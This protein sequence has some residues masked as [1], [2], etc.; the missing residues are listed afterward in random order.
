LGEYVIGIGPLW[1]RVRRPEPVKVLALLWVAQDLIGLLDLFE[2]LGIATFVW[3]V[4]TGEFAISLFDVIGRGGR[5]QT[6]DVVWCLRRHSRTL[7]LV[8]N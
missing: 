1:R 6:E 7:I 4:L 5:G 3:M 2:L 8:T